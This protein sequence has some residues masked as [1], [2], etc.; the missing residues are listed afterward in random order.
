MYSLEDRIKAVK[1]YIIYSKRLLTIGVN[2]SQ[3][4]CQYGLSAYPNWTKNWSYNSQLY[5]GTSRTKLEKE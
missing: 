1:L 3:C 5:D 4:S 2:N